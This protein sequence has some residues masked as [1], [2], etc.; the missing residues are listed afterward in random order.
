MNKESNCKAIRERESNQNAES[1][2]GE[3]IEE[4]DNVVQESQPS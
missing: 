2:N 3:G 4:S 1:D